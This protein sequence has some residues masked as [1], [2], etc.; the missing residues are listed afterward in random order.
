MANRKGKSSTLNKDKSHRINAG[1][2]TNSGMSS[3]KA[4]D[5]C[6]GWILVGALVL[7]PLIVGAKLILF[8]SPVI[9][10]SAM[11]SGPKVNIF[12]YYK[13]LFL[14]LLTGTALILLLTKV[15]VFKD[16]LKSRQML[17]PL[18][19]LMFLTSLSAAVAQYPGIVLTG[20]YAR[21]E[22][23]TTIVAYLILSIVALN[24]PITRLLVDR[25]LKGLAFVAL[26]IAIMSLTGFYGLNFLESSFIRGLIVPAEL[27]P[28]IQ[29]SFATPLSNSNYVSGF[30]GALVVFFTVLAMLSR[31]RREVVVNAILAVA[32][33][34]S[35]AASI[36]TSGYLSI[37]V[38]LPVILFLVI[39][40]EKRMRLFT[41]GLP[42]VAACI[43]LVFILSAHNPWVGD[44]LIKIFGNQTANAQ[45]DIT[46]NNTEGGQ[47]GVSSSSS[48]SLNEQSP[49][50]KFSTGTG[51]LYIWQKTGELILKR[52]LLGYGP[53]ALPFYFP[54]N[55]IDKVSNLGSY[56]LVVDKPHNMY[57]GLAFNSGIPV[58]LIFLGMICLWFYR[59]FIRIVQKKNE[60][61]S[62][63]HNAV[64]VF[65]LAFLVQWTVNDSYIGTSPI[66]WILLGLAA[67][68]DK[69]SSDLN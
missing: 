66:F 6:L 4:I 29:G 54:Q 56:N 55:D 37:F 19:V 21:Y 62:I 22:G 25:L 1:A 47:V 24:T 36:S 59:S 20:F 64:L 18:C 38:S 43:G 51:R 57:V 44:E 17:M 52:P 45:N 30:S 9:S 61:Q 46:K 65:I 12:T 26:I 31:L 33:F 67:P 40:N 50:A 63:F 11:L 23:M 68:D 48:N 41:T 16:K 42:I 69:E 39:F 34:A 49:N 27:V 53:D 60:P 58:L 10:N 32:S 8:L 2:A 14:L 35:L 3:I 13:W 7:L 15:F 28:Y 5:S